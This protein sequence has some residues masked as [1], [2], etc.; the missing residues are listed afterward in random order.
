[1]TCVPNNNCHS[2]SP[3]AG[4]LQTT[5]NAL[6]RDMEMDSQKKPYRFLCHFKDCT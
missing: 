5:P 1:M 4:C 3:W 6:A 2:P